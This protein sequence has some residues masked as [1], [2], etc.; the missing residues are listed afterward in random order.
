MVYPSAIW[1]VLE[2]F[3]GILSTETFVRETAFLDILD[4]YYA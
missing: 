4:I 2:I 1:S 3:L